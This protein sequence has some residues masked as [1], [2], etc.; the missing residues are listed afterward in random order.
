MCVFGWCWGCM[1]NRDDNQTHTRL[2]S[3]KP[4]PFNTRMGDEN[5]L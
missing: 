2:R 3:E 1:E 5:G 4:T